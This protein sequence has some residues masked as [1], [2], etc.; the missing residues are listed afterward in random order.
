MQYVDTAAIIGCYLAIIGMYVYV[1]KSKQEILEMVHK[2]ETEVDKHVKSEELVHKAVCDLQVKTFE[3]T[4]NQLQSDI[5]NV[6][7]ELKTDINNGF[8]EVKDLIKS[9]K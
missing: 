1:F 8:R 2:H 7:S 6:K 4:M 5:K 3:N 9:S